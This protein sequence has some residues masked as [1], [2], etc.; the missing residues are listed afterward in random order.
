[1][2]ALN[3]QTIPSNRA[4]DPYVRPG[5]HIAIKD[6]AHGTMIDG[7]VEQDTFDSKLGKVNNILFLAMICIIS[8]SISILIQV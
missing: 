6:H 7:K 3:F 8:Q 4:K 5:D 1:M 2:R